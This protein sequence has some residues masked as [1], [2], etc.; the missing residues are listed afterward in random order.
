[1]YFCDRLLGCGLSLVLATFALAEERRSEYQFTGAHEHGR[2]NLFVV[3]EREELQIEFQSP[4]MSLLGF[5]HDARTEGQ[6]KE[7]DRL[8][9]LLEDE[10]A[11]I[12][13]KGGRCE[14][15]SV[16]VDM[17]GLEL[18]EH[19]EKHNHNEAEH[20]EIRVLYSFRCHES[21]QLNSIRL[22]LFE[23]F[24]ALERVDAQWIV[25][26]K[27]GAQTLRANQ[28]LIELQ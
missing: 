17:Q 1:M 10:R 25:R 3:M 21:G 27:Q 19:E 13:L 23:Q 24:P 15:L 14:R 6:K 11:L 8:H 2:A 22:V 12:I 20:S 26:S 28:P 4:G 5:E 18:D 16:D 9:H 7:L